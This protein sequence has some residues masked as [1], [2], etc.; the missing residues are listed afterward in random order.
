[1]SLLVAPLR[2]IKFEVTWRCP[3][4]C[5]HCSSEASPSA[6]REMAWDA[7]RRVLDEAAQLGAESVAFS[8]GEP[9][10]WGPLVEG[11]AHASSLGAGVTVYTSGY[12][13]DVGDR[14]AELQ[15]AGLSRAIFSIYA[16]EAPDHDRVT[17]VAG[18]FD[19]TC[20][21][22][23]CSAALG[24]ATELHVVAMSNTYRRLPE[25][26]RLGEAL[27]ASRTSVLRF[28]PQGRGELVMSSALNRLQSLELRSMVKQLLGDGHDLRLGSPWSYLMLGEEAHCPA[29]EDR[30]VVSPDLN[31]FPCDAFKQKDPADLVGTRDL[32]CLVT[33]DL[34]Q[35]WLHSPFLEA[36]R[37][38]RLLSPLGECA[39]CAG[40]RAC[41]SGCMAQRAVAGDGLAM[42]PDPGCLR[43]RV[44]ARHA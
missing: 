31:I 22:I 30:I 12:L 15:A 32:C 23:Q 44:G 5:L 26:V 19:G 18:S 25:I 34:E 3:L 43:D 33:S 42:T 27:G 39:G 36:V 28:V 2:D 7:C 37:E 20:S 41:G 16:P 24:L 9:L 38:A 17:R 11:V 13:E 40:H 10:L 8:G 4:V 1:M 14:L 35:A 21:A 29:A 6:D